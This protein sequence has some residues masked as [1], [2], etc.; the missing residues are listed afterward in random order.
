M[1]DDDMW[2][3]YKDDNGN[4]F[5]Q[6]WNDLTDVGTLIDEETGDDMAIVGWTTL[7]PNTI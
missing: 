5:Y 2:L 3:V 4:L 1:I 7:N 6:H